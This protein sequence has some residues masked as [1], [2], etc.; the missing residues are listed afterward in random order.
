MRHVG[1]YIY[2]ACPHLA[3]SVGN[4]FR[5]WTRATCEKVRASQLL[6]S[7][8]IEGILYVLLTGCRW[9][10]LPREYGVPTTIGVK[11]V[12]SR[13]RKGKNE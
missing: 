9:Q 6:S 5:N 4:S 2:I 8:T 12:V 3:A 1:F 7:D 10:D 13:R 11:T